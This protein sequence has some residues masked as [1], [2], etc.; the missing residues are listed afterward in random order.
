MFSVALDAIPPTVMDAMRQDN[1]WI[2]VSDVESA[3]RE[4]RSNSDGRK[5]R[6]MNLHHRRFL[7]SDKDGDGKLNEQEL[8]IM[9]DMEAA[10]YDVSV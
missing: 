7:S 5:N 8:R 2:S 10:I 9:M 1:R 4:N 6:D 3:K